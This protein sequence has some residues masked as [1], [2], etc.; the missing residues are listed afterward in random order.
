MERNERP[1]TTLFQDIQK[2]FERTYTNIGI[3]LEECI[4]D[5]HRCR[6]LTKLAG[7]QAAELS[8]LGRT[9][10]RSTGGHLRIGIYFSGWL[11]QQLEKHDPRGGIGEQNIRE[12][13]TFVEEI[14]HALHGALWFQRGQAPVGHEQYAR[15]L[16]LQASVDTY[17]VLLLF[18][19]FF[20]RPGRLTA[21]DRRWLRFHCFQERAGA[22]FHR[23]SLRSRYAE[24]T[25]L[26]AHY[27]GYLESLSRQCRL[28]E[29]QRFHALEYPA[30]VQHILSLPAPTRPG[31]EHENLES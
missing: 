20:R 11:I 29:I 24:T 9:F 6:Q 12:L 5:R 25:R 22:D 8:D 31:D 17:L 13:I 3:N 27:T 28:A 4:I 19:A 2:L 14:N 23:Q 7:A 26:A 10:L 30:K 18:M 1:P 15:N 16:E 21:F